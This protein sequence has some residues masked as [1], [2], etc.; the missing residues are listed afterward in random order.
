MRALG[1]RC[2]VKPHPAESGGEYLRRGIGMSDPAIA[3]A[4]PR[5]RTCSTCC[6]AA[7]ALVTV[8][9]LSAVEALVLG[10][11]VVILNTPTNLRALVEAGVA[12]GVAAGDDPTDA[13]RRALFDAETRNAPAARARPCYLDELALGVDGQATRAHR[14]PRCGRPRPRA[15]AAVPVGPERHGRV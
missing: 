9:S 5:P 13:L 2:L 15:G 6:I 1:V 10:R 4:L 7:D 12:L 11:P 8:E 14:R 3:R